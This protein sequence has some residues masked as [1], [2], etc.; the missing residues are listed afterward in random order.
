[1]A[2]NTAS[3]PPER[4][5]WLEQ[6][7]RRRQSRLLRLLDHSFGLRLLLAA[8]LASLALAGVNRW[9]QCRDL[10]FARGCAWRDA[11]GVVSVSNL[12]SFSIMTAGILFILEG[13]KRRQREHLEAMEMILACQKAGVRFAP[14]RNDA[15]ELVSHA[16]LELHHWD[17]SGIDLDQ[18]RIAGAR[19]QGVNLSGS[20]LRH[21]D[22]RRADLSEANLRAADLSNADLRGADLRQA[23]L[24]DADLSQADLRGALLEGA[25][26]DG[27]VLSG[28]LQDAASAVHWSGRPR[29]YGP[30]DPA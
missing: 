16:G 22:L 13:G 25:A 11:G 28:S 27:A 20:S 29:P 5:T 23:D 2:P 8:A 17:L 21:A 7:R 3:P 12:E 24:S 6:Q 19:W 9:E 26:L 14:A 15:L 30:S 10:G 1:M 18:L 4:P